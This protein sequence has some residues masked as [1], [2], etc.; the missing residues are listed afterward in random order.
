MKEEWKT[1][2]GYNDYMVSSYGRVKSKK[3]G[4]E[5]I[6]K[7][8][9]NK[10]GYFLVILSKDKIKNT[11]TVHRLVAK[12]F[13][14][15]PKNKSQVNHKDGNKLNNHT[16]NLEWVT[17]KENMKHA[18]KSGLMERGEDRYNAKLTEEDV[19]EIRATSGWVCTMTELAEKYDVSITL[20]SQI[21][22]RNRWKHI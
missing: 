19:L 9:L 10:Y 20:I 18:S 2:D 4:N 12:A 6:L 5:R 16:E 15:N 11:C 7:A 22:K 13:I 21:K 17:N 14:P 1:I 3:C 8:G